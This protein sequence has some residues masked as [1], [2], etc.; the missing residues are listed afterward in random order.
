MLQTLRI[1]IIYTLEYWRE[2]NNTED[3]LDKAMVYYDTE[4]N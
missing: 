2:S 4:R 1:G 3:N